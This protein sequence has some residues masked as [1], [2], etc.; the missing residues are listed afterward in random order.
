MRARRREPDARRAE[1]SREEQLQ[2]EQ[3]VR[4][5]LQSAEEAEQQLLQR[6]SKR[7]RAHSVLGDVT[8]SHRRHGETFRQ[9]Q[10][11]T[12]RKVRSILVWLAK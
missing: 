4:A 6:T 7:S 5:Q 1:K 8:P 2:A 11:S 3:Q 12:A 9:R 10:C